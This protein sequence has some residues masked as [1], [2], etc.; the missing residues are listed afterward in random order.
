MKDERIDTLF[1]ALKNEVPSV[2]SNEVFEWLDHQPTA[3]LLVRRNSML[4]FKLVLLI[5]GMGFIAALLLM[6]P[7]NNDPEKVLNEPEN[8]V[9]SSE[10]KINER[11]TLKTEDPF[12]LNR[13]AVVHENVNDSV[14]TNVILNFEPAMIPLLVDVSLSE[15]GSD[16]V[17]DEDQ[18]N[19]EPIKR[20]EQAQIRDLLFILD[21]LKTYARPATRFT[22]DEPD[23][24]LQI[25]KD[26]AVISY[27][28]RNRNHYAAG[29]IHRE[30]TQLI[31]GKTYKVFA[32][33]SDNQ[34]PSSNFGNRVFFGY[35]EIE[36]GSNNIEILFF[37]QPWAPTTILIGHTASSE[38][39]RKLVERSKSQE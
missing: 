33:Q 30:E 24:Y 10:R 28:F 11:D 38:E 8:L 16:A 15:D 18:L 26:Y 2:G 1:E 3:E 23:C 13:T 37:N 39:R 5:I 25:Y 4:R 22:M 17:N 31:D 14:D 34:A 6:L 7:V 27:R 35:R 9:Q 19:V 36:N 12:R 21:S 20:T 29:T 32:F